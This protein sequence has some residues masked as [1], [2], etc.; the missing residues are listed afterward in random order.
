LDIIPY[1]D[2]I[3]KYQNKYNNS[4]NNGSDKQNITRRR[5]IKYVVGAIIAAGAGSA[6][7]ATYEAT[8]QTPPSVL[9]IG[10]LADKTGALAA[11]GYAH[12]RVARA[13]VNKINRA[14][15][16]ANR[17]IELI[18]EDTESAGPV[19]ALKFRKLIETYNVDFIIGSNTSAVVLPCV[20]IAKELRTVYFPT[21]G[22]SPIEPHGNR[23][24][25]DLNTNVVQETKAVA[26]FAVEKIG[27]NW[28][29]V[30]V[31][32]AWGWDQ[33]KRF[34]KHITEAGG[35][36]LYSTR[37][38]LGTSDFLPYL[39]KI[40]AKTEGVYFANFGSDFLSFIRDLY[41]VRPDI[42]KFGGNYVL[43]GQD[44]QK[45]KEYV[46][47]TYVITMF[48]TRLEGLDT[49]YNRA[50]R[51]E[52][53]IDD[54]GRDIN[55]KVDM[56]LSYSWSTWTTLF[57]IKQGIEETGWKTKADTPIFIKWLEGRGFKES[58]E[59]PQGDKWIRA[60]DHV[61]FTTL[62]IEQVKGGKTKVIKKIPAEDTIYPPI[63]DYTKESF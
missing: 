30:V 46:E 31:D 3:L 38:P 11:Y 28:A 18:V 8:R 49:P 13:A 27:K 23:Y 53:G 59:N 9:R 26:N 12:E 19:G 6:I 4:M 14:G 58:Y 52:C 54:E 34:E 29:I 25:F 10:M 41:S 62:Y 39:A 22:G 35:T 24:V 37:V 32:Y 33:E 7:F 60:Q 5:Y 43:S 44:L 16:I 2:N 50:F 48:P 15:G 1:P 61:D 57:T 47:D 17:P 36:V 55:T 21:A 42:A 40:P 56:V 45:I 20:P 63:V 51:N